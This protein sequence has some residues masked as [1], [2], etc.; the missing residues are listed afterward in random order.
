ML[1]ASSTISWILN[2]ENDILMHFDGISSVVFAMGKN[3]QNVILF[4]KF[5]S[6]V[7]PFE[8][9]LKMVLAK[10]KGRGQKKKSPYFAYFILTY[11]FPNT[12]FKKGFKYHPCKTLQIQRAGDRNPSQNLKKTLD[13]KI[14][15]EWNSWRR[16]CC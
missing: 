9:H 11:F 14:K 13:F 16:Q 10:T 2:K 1:T 15:R 6:N 4:D 12:P 8:H 7:F 5:H 3:E